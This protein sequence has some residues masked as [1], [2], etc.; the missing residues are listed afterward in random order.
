MKFSRVVRYILS[1][2]PNPLTPQQIRDCIKMKYPDLYG[3]PSHIKNVEKGHYKDN[4]HALLAQIYS[5]VGTNKDFCCDKSVK[6]MKISLTGETKPAMQVPIMAYD[7][8]IRKI[9]SRGT[10]NWDAKVR[11]I[12]ENAETY[13]QAYYEAETF[14]GPSLYFHLRAL[15]TRSEPGSSEHLEY[16]YATLSSWGMHRMGKGGSKMQDFETFR[17]SVAPLI[18]RLVSIHKNII[19][20]K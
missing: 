18:N 7:S 9:P 19:T 8:V 6:P 5:F 2:S 13:Q 15:Y 10:T 12:L 4:D 16:V 17:E 20:K 3:N 11:D 1:S 14:L